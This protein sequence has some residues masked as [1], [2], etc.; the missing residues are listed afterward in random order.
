MSDIQLTSIEVKT[1]GSPLTAA[2]FNILNAA[3]NL[4]SV[5][6]VSV[7]NDPSLRLLAGLATGS[8][9]VVNLNAG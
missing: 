9:Y 8:L 3:V 1:A 5:E 7:G 2:E 4:L 6:A